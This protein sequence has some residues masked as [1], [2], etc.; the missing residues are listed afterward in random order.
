MRKV[1][2]KDFNAVYD[3]VGE[4]IKDEGIFT[5][6]Q[7]HMRLGKMPQATITEIV[8]G[9]ADQEVLVASE[10]TVRFTTTFTWGH[11]ATP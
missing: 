10:K 2:A 6:T 3:A 9:L 8:L 1:S 7:V 5:L 11:K 4:L